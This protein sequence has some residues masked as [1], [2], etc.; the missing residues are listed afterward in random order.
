MA[1]PPQGLAGL[2]ECEL[3]KPQ[4]PR[5]F[6]V[7]SD[8]APYWVK[9]VQE[10]GMLLRLRKGSATALLA[11]ELQALKMMKAR[12]LMVPELALEGPA[13][14]VTRDAGATCDRL[15]RGDALPEDAKVELLLR[16][17][18]AVLALHHGAAAHGGLH[19]RNICD[20][21]GVI[22]FIDLEKAIAQNA[23]M[24]A[25]AYDLRVL[26]F[27]VFAVLP[28]R[29][30]L[31]KIVL[32]TYRQEAPEQVVET[33]RAWARAHWWMAPLVRPLKWHENRFK[34]RREYRQYNALAPAL[35]VL[36]GTG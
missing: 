19:L 29:Y 35:K 2:V 20:K 34:P 32:D 11:N 12:G 30:D 6:M 27:S 9:Q 15:L 18:R 28:Y 23:D 31:A 3:R 33:A 13:Y 1:L 26:V 17:V 25:Q 21:D 36:S 14:M 10:R 7:L 16:A 4:A 24:E 8:G 5:A 22:R